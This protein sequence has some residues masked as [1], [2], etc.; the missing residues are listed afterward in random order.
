MRLESL[1][2]IVA[3]LGDAEGANELRN[4]L[5]RSFDGLLDPGG[6]DVRQDGPKPIFAL[7]IFEGLI[8]KDR[9]RSDTIQQ[10]ARLMGIVVVALLLL[11]LF[12]Q[13]ADGGKYFALHR[14]L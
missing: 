2:A 3:V 13:V 14:C 1:P 5:A 7:F 10:Q 9:R 12:A 8:K 6:C 11:D 4:F